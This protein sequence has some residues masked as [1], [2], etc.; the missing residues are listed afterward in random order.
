[1]SRPN[2]WP[3]AY[4]LRQK[5]IISPILVTK[6]DGLPRWFLRDIY[7]GGYNQRF[8]NLFDSIITL[9]VA[10]KDKK[11]NNFN[12]PNQSNVQDLISAFYYLS[13]IFMIPQTLK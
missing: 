13:V 2:H 3:N 11:E 5:I 9:K 10:V 12:T 1:M 4:F 7:E 8:G 6:Y